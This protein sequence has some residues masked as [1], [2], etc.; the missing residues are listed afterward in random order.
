MP[1]WNP[2]RR[3]QSTNEP[4]GTLH[5]S[6]V[7]Q[8]EVGGSDRERGESGVGVGAWFAERASEVSMRDPG[9]DVRHAGQADGLLSTPLRPPAVGPLTTLLPLALLAGLATAPAAARAPAPRPHGSRLQCA[10]PTLSQCLDPAWQATWCGKLE[11]ARNRTTEGSTCNHL[12][13]VRAAALAATQ[14]EALVVAPIIASVAGAQHLAS[15]FDGIE[16]DATPGRSCAL[17]AGYSQRKHFAAGMTGMVGRATER[18]SLM[19]LS[20]TSAAAATFR[21]A[22]TQRRSIWEANGDAVKSCREYVYEKYFDYSLFEDET[23]RFANDPRAVVGTAFGPAGLR[24]SIGTRGALGQLLR[25]HDNTPFETTI[26]FPTNQKKNTF[27]T[28]PPDAVDVVI[29]GV[30]HNFFVEPNCLG[31]EAVYISGVHLNDPSLRALLDADPRHDE[32]FAW[33]RAMSDAQFERGVLDE[34]LEVY[35]AAR[36]RYAA[37]LANRERVVQA[38]RDWLQAMVNKGKEA[39]FVF[40]DIADFRDPY[41]NPD[42]TASF[43]EL[44]PVDL[45]EQLGF[46]LAAELAG[47]S[48]PTAQYTA[49]FNVDPL[50][51]LPDITPIPSDAVSLLDASEA[52]GAGLCV[53]PI[54]TFPEHIMFLLADLDTRIEAALVE[55]RDLGCLDIDDDTSPCDWAPSLFSQRVVDLF[56]TERENDFETCLEYTGN[57]FTRLEDRQFVIPDPFE[58]VCPQQNFT[59]SPTQVELYVACHDEW[60]RRVLAVISEQLGH[61]VLD[62]RTGVLDVGMTRSGAGTFGNDLFGVAFDWESRWDVAGWK[63]AALAD[64]DITKLQPQAAGHVI[65]TGTMFGLDAEL[66]N[67]QLKVTRDVVD[68]DLVLNV[69]GL[70]IVVY[71]FDPERLLDPTSVGTVADS[72]ARTV[73]F[74]KAE[75]TVYILGIPVTI[76]GSVDGTVG[77]DY[78]AL[79]ALRTAP[80]AQ[81]LA[82]TLTPFVRVDA[83]ASASVDLAIIEAGVKGSIVLIDLRNP[84][85]VGLHIYTPPGGQDQLFG[86]QSSSTL[87]S[88]T[89]AGRIAVFGEIDLGLFSKSAELTVAQWAGRT[90][91]RSLYDLHFTVPTEPLYAVAINPVLP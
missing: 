6:D 63:Q 69:G 1:T 11:R 49:Q 17:Q 62:P 70:D 33:H 59:T 19:P 84:L 10:T 76:R 26:D 40:P 45:S 65:A 31:R 4:G 44:D 66:I 18:M 13:Q 89:L 51:G 34:E 24:R 77:V 20:N 48:L 52:F 87:S 39:Q 90:E 71:G 85:A 15:P 9:S 58:V 30:L 21:A 72:Q 42:P 56:V 23:T 28:T 29:D 88:N 55:A 79:A 37:L 53:N 46:F 91:S 25:Q 22:E 16:C 83:G 60:V 75:H 47:A 2:A 64:N 27:F 57:N 86:V 35:A 14:N 82:L 54:T 73:N 61:P 43:D 78:T 74:I 68:V 80:D 36:E 50:P 67:A 41:V 5:Q 8:V 7:A 38:F 81:D 32:S 12:L 3:V